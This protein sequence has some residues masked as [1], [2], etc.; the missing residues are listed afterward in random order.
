[1]VKTMWTHLRAVLVLGPI[2]AVHV[3]VTLLYAIHTVTTQCC[4][5]C[6]NSLGQ[7]LSSFKMAVSPCTIIREASKDSGTK[8]GPKSGNGF[9]KSD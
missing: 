7:V 9:Q 2:V 6:G 4:H 1:M 5:L 3:T 8:P